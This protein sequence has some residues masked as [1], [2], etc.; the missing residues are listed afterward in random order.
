MT[1]TDRGPL[2]DTAGVAALLGLAPGSI[3][4]YRV[5]GT[6]PPPDAMLGNSPG[7]H[8]ATIREWQATRPGRTGRPRKQL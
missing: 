7:W 6:L 2:L 8:E 1:T 3:R 4:T 5:R